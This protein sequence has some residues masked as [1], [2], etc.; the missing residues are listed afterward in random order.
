M[1]K[2]HFRGTM[3]AIPF[4][5]VAIIPS[6][7]EIALNRRTESE[8]GAFEWKSVAADWNKHTRNDNL[9]HQ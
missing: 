4:A 6:G 2:Y 1:L 5:R 8:A 9:F 7:A 3:S